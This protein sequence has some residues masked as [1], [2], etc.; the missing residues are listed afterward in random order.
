MIIHT[1]INKE[2]LLSKKKPHLI[3]NE[4]ILKNKKLN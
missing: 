4:A 2:Y 1:S 3:L